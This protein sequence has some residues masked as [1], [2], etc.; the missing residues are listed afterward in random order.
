[1]KLVLECMKLKFGD[2]FKEYMKSIGKDI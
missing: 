1:V 2:D